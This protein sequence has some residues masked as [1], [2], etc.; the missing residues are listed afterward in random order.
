MARH[1]FGSTN[2]E[3][4][5]ELN[6][7]N[8]SLRKRYS[9][10][11]YLFSNCLLSSRAQESF[12]E[13]LSRAFESLMKKENTFFLSDKLLFQFSCRLIPNQ[14][15]ICRSIVVRFSCIC[16]YKCNFIIWNLLLPPTTPSWHSWNLNSSPKK[17]TSEL[18]KL[19]FVCE[20]PQQERGNLR[21]IDVF[22]FIKSNDAK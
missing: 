13:S 3:H 19:N 1:W 18:S 22:L 11:F 12:S 20:F 15:L 21:M 17:K 4:L 5:K 10:Q 16:M 2:I 6:Y 7:L 8:L 14:W 9:M